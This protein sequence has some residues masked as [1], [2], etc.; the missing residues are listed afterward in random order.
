MCEGP[1]DRLSLIEEQVSGSEEEGET[2]RSSELAVA[3]GS[4]TS[5]AAQYAA[6]HNQPSELQ[7]NSHSASS[8]KRSECVK[9][10]G[11]VDLDAVFEELQ[12][13][14]KQVQALQVQPPLDF[15]P[16]VRGGEKRQR[17]R[18]C[19]LTTLDIRRVERMRRSGAWVLA[20]SRALPAL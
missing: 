7:I 12:A 19:P 17:R 6:R 18:V 10:L 15:V 13:K 4:L 14:R 1:P 2:P 8:S 9:D 11:D 20:S 3:D 5:W 16:W